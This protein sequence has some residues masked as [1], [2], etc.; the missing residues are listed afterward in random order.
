MA[1]SK[2]ETTQRARRR[3][4]KTASGY[5]HLV[6]SIGGLIDAARQRVAQTVN[7]EMARLYWEIGR[8]IVEDEQGGSDWAQYGARRLEHP[9]ADLTQRYGR[10][11][12][13]RTLLYM[14]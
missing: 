14:G 4:P 11:F 12:S 5:A 7:T 10:G 9:S 2:P 6:E 3:K 13:L 1:K 8:H